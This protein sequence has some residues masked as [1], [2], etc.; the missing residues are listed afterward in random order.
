MH[1][2]SAELSQFVNLNTVSLTLNTVI[3][4]PHFFIQLRQT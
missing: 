2:Y 1:S 3:G 4:F